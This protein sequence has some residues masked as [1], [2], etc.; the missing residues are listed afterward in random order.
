MLE[1]GEYETAFHAFDEV[2]KLEE[3]KDKIPE[4]DKY[5]YRGI[6]REKAGKNG[7]LKDWKVAEKLGSKKATQLLKRR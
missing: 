5:I 1:T 7:F 6:A 2:L 3:G 4:A